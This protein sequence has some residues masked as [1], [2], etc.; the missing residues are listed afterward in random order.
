MTTEVHAKKK[1]SPQD[2]VRLDW[3]LRAIDYNKETIL[4]WT[5]DDFLN[6]S[7]KT[8]Q[9]LSLKYDTYGDSFTEPV[10]KEKLVNLFKRIDE[11][12]RNI[13]VIAVIYI[14]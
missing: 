4:D 9:K 3:F 1:N 12:V 14:I 6:M 10:S 2:I 8:K 5:P 11:E 7:Q 13:K